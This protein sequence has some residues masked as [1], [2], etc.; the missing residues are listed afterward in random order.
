MHRQG[1]RPLEVSHD[2]KLVTRKAFEDR[3]SETL[4]RFQNKGFVK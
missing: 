2:D 4:A 1:A 3:I